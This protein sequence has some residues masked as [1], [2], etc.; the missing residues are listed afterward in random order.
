MSSVR[1]NNQEIEKY[2]RE[3]VIVKKIVAENLKKS[4]LAKVDLFEKLLKTI[5]KETKVFFFEYSRNINLSNLKPTLSF[6]V[7]FAL[8]I[9]SFET[10]IFSFA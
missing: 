1:Q 7:P 10:A 5:K 4:E 2:L 9:I 6:S 3:L 8:L